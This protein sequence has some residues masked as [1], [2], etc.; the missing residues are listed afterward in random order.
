MV[1]KLL[2]VEDDLFLIKVYESKMA[3]AGFEVK[4]AKDGIEAEEILKTFT[5]DLILLDLIMPRKDGFETLKDLKASAKYRSI[6]VMVTSNLGQSED[7]KKAESLGAIDY[8]VKSD[9]P[10]QKLVELINSRLA[11]KVAK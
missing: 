8:I 7:K 2:I 9:T 10:I 4:L 5:P 3:K 1:K 11:N 6:P